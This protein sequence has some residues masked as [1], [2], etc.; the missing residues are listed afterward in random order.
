MIRSAYDIAS[1]GLDE[2][3]E[4]QRAFDNVHALF[5]FLMQI[6][7]KDHVAQELGQLGIAEVNDWSEKIFGWSER[8]ERELGHLGLSEVTQ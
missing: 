3:R 2:L 6:V 1:T 4:V 7:P 8:M 5:T